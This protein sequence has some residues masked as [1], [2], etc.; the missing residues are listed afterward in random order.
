MKTFKFTWEEIGIEVL[1]KFPKLYTSV[2]IK[3]ILDK[4]IENYMSW[5]METAR[6]IYK[7]KLKE[8]ER[9]NACAFYMNEKNNRI[10]EKSLRVW[11]WVCYSPVTL[12]ELSDNE[13]AVKI[14]EL[15]Q[16]DIFKKTNPG[17]SGMK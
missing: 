1:K 9:F 17:S 14:K 3:K 11:D 2:R 15:V 4:N 6:K 8:N 7:K 16:R 5:I 12:E 10:L 13:Y